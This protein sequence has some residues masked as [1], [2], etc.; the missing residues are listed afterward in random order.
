MSFAVVR[1]LTPR[2]FVIAIRAFNLKR[3][4]LRNAVDEMIICSRARSNNEWT[5]RWPVDS[6]KRRLPGLY[7]LVSVWK[8]CSKIRGVSSC[9]HLSEN[10]RKIQVKS[11]S[12]ISFDV[13]NYKRVSRIAGYNL[14]MI[15]TRAEFPL[16]FLRRDLRYFSW[17]YFKRC[18]RK[19]RKT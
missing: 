12:D 13:F 19:S 4:Y 17:Q 15:L 1:L 3:V 10:L 11:L 5:R 2:R 14:L 18:L 6:C 16:F 9:F 8:A 7:T